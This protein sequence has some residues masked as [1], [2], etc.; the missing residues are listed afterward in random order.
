MA[1][2]NEE[3]EKEVG[4]PVTPASSEGNEVEAT[5]TP[6]AA[7]PVGEEEPAAEV[8]VTEETVA[9]RCPEGK[10]YV[11]HTYSG[12]E[13]QA[14]AS[15]EERI[16]SKKMESF[17][18]DILI[19]SE[20]VVEMVKGKKR[21][22]TRRFFPGYLLVKMILDDNTWHLVKSTPKITGFV[23]GKVR[24]PSIP[25][26]E[27]LR[28]TRQIAEGSLRPKQRLSF[29]K[30]ES[31][32]VIEGPFVNFNGVVDEVKPEKGKLRVLV[33]IFGRSTPVELDFS[34]VEKN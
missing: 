32:R 18:G 8:P 22:S 33:S 28:L 25:E 30:G 17:F 34:Q 3:Q 29:E 24:P 11:V 19:P 9:D 10:W 7:E 1:S 26:G 13:K 23:G 15:L 2:M 21:T 20:N 6:V 31:V 4:V 14:K 27:V 16:R 12:F 5:E